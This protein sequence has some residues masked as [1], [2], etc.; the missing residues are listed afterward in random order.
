MLQLETAS[1]SLIEA[2]QL[3]RLQLGLTRILPRN[4]FYEEKLLASGESITMPLL[5][6]HPTPALFDQQ[7]QSTSW[8]VVLLQRTKAISMVHQQVQ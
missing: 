6:L 8:F 3:A 1:R 5:L 4:R 7:Q 2:H